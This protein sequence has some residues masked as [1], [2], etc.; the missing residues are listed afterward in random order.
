MYFRRGSSQSEFMRMALSVMLSTVRSFIGGRLRGGILDGWLI[1]LIEDGG[2]DD[3]EWMG[4]G[5]IY[6]GWYNW[7]TT[8]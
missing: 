6:F 3:P 2:R 5:D 1:G 8:E 4:C 7:S